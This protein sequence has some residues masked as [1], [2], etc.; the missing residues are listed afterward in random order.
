MGTKV[1]TKVGTRVGT[2]VGI[3]AGTRVESVR[4]GAHTCTHAHLL[5]TMVERIRGWNEMRWS[6][7]IRKNKINPYR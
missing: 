1:G 4:S 6:D 3:R 7:D 2:I 5:T